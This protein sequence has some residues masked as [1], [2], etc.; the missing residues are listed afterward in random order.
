MVLNDAIRTAEEHL[1]TVVK[2][3]Y[4]QPR[5]RWVVVEDCV[6]DQGDSWLLHYQSETFLTTDDISYAL[7]GNQ[8]LRV[9]KDG[10]ILGFQAS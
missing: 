9:S 1:N 7:A 5:D 6:Q 2:S 4:A 3:K 8:P 10:R